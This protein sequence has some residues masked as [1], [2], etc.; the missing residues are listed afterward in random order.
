MKEIPLTKG[1]VALVDDEDYEALAK[2]KWHA[3]KFSQ[4]WC[5]ARNV[6]GDDGV[7]RIVLMHRVIMGAPPGA[8]VDHRNH[9]G[10]D[11]RRE[12]LRVCTR[13]QNLRNQRKRAG[14]SSRLKGVSLCGQTGRWAAALKVGT[15][16]VWLGRF[17]T[18]ADAGAAYDR[19]AR[20]HFGEFACLNEVLRCA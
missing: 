16:K 17:K 8:D 20:E 2:F 18:E 14:K 4:T 10:C 6:R 12:N 11:N 1:Q 19:A 3:H 7:K 15:K 9:N 5:A 13:Q